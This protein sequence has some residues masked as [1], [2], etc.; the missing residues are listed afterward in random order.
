MHEIKIKPRKYEVAEILTVPGSGVKT[1]RVRR[2]GLTLASAL[3][4]QKELKSR[5]PYTRISVRLQKAVK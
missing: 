4:A 2:R 5:H 3:K 1:H